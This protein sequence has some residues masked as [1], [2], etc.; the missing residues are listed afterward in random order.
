MEKGDIFDSNF[1]AI[2]LH[3][4]ILKVISPIENELSMKLAELKSVKNTTIESKNTSLIENIDLQNRRIYLLANNMEN[5]IEK[6]K[7]II[8]QLDNNI[9]RY[10]NHK[11]V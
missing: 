11:A 7:N 10:I 4:D 6:L 2:Q 1:Y 9:I 3:R 8:E 5:A